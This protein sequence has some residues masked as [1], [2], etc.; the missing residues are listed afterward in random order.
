MESPTVTGSTKQR[1]NHAQRKF[2]AVRKGH[3]KAVEDLVLKVWQLQWIHSY[4]ASS[5]YVQMMIFS[6][7]HVLPW[8]D[9]QLYTAQLWLLSLSATHLYCWY[10]WLFY[11]VDRVWFNMPGYIDSSET[12]TATQVLKKCLGCFA[13]VI[14]P[15]SLSLYPNREALLGGDHWPPS[16]PGHNS[17][18]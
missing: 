6:K 3:R 1:K 14:F 17:S 12:Q 11:S 5:W 7:S 4:L 8:F 15:S 16:T 13:I 18:P 2:Q 9:Q 10:A